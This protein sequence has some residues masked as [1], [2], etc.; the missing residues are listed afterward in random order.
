M[1]LLQYSGFVDFRDY[2]DLFSLVVAGVIYA[3]DI[4][5]AKT[6]ENRFKRTRKPTEPEY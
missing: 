6:S 4:T 5:P 1:D 3:V 2:F